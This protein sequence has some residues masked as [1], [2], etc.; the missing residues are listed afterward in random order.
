[1]IPS[2]LTK[3]AGVQK[4]NRQLALEADANRLITR[5]ASERLAKPHGILQ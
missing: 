4:K 1:M 3:H 2:H 5:G